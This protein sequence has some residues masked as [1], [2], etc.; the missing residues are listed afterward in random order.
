MAE[1]YPVGIQSFSE[2][3]QKGMTYVDKTPL[4]HELLFSE[5]SGQ[6]N[7]F[8]SRPRRFGKSLLISTLRAILEGKKELFQ[9]YWIY[10]KIQWE[11]HPIIHLSMI[12]IDFARKGLVPALQH[13]LREIAEEYEVVLKDD[14]LNDLIKALYKR[15]QKTVVIL[16]DEYDKPII[17]GLEQGDVALAEKH[18]D[19]MKDF[20]GG[21]KE[22][23]DYLRFFFIT[24][25]SKFARV[26]IFSDLNHLSDITLDKRFATLCGYTHTELT[27]HFPQGIQRLAQNYGLTVEACLTKIKDWYNGFSWDGEHFVYNPF[28]TLRLLETLQFGNYWFET[29]TPTFLVK[30]L[31]EKEIFQLTDIEIHTGL[32]QTFDLHQLDTLSLLLQTGYFTLKRKLAEFIFEAD[33]PNQEV[34]ES[35]HFL[36][37]QLSKEKLREV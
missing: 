27:T 20:Y 31:R 21:L 18:R 16:V 29:G 25:V 11:S 26:S 34:R 35:F 13:R 23:G 4:I 12:E 3:V 7:F 19:I 14:S 37:T 2:L 6:K 8:L 10:D 32:F 5:T 24:G 30:Q 1:K 28:S 17:H 9:H 15:Y 22:L 36:L 33:F